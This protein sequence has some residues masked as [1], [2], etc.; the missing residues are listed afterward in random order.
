LCCL[1]GTQKS[2]AKSSN[3]TSSRQENELKIKIS[4]IY[5][6]NPVSKALPLPREFV[7]VSPKSKDPSI[8]P[9]RSKETDLFL[10]FN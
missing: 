7:H 2:Y 9:G 1:E 4:A 6:A 8:F 5:R 10:P 3:I